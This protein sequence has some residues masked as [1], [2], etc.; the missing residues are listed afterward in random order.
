MNAT[1]VLANTAYTEQE[2]KEMFC[3]PFTDPRDGEV[4]KT[5]MIGTQVWMAENLRFRPLKGGS[6]AYDKDPK[7]VPGYGRLYSREVAKEACPPGWHLPSEEEWNALFAFVGKT[8]DISDALRKKS[9][10]DGLDAFGFKAVP[11]GLYG[12]YG[13]YDKIFSNMHSDAFYWLSGEGESK[14]WRL[15]SG[16]C[17][18]PKV[19][20][21]G[22]FEDDGN[23]WTFASCYF[24]IR[25]IKG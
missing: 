3:K 9:W 4:Y 21:S 10:D 6:L 8:Y 2:V 7:N 23:W 25:C 19:V 17:D 11:S 15:G 12:N 24:A 13:S 18:C 5:C 22:I 20:G 16:Y 1:D 14:F